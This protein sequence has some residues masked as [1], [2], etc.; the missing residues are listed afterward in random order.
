MGRAGVGELVREWRTQRRRSQMDLALDVGVST[1]HL[2]FVETGRSRPSPELVLALAQRLDVP[3]RER[4]ALLLS[5]GY[6]P[7]FS[8]RPLDDPAMAHVRA[9]MQRMLD[10]HDPYPGA[11]IDRQWNVVMANRAAGMMT[12]GIDH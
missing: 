11:V 5:A 1:R 6:A 7:R 12:A 10:A 3:L 2:S 4:N 9:S 8:Q